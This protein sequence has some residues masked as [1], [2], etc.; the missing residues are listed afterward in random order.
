MKILL[1][2]NTVL[3]TQGTGI[4]VYKETGKFFVDLAQTGN[5]VIVFQ[6]LMKMDSLGFLNDFNIS[7]KGFKIIGVKRGNFKFIAYLKAFFIGYNAVKKADFIYL[8]YPGH[9]CSFLAFS[10][11]LNKKRYG[12]YVR[13][14]KGIMSAISRYLYKRASVVLTISPSFT[15]SIKQL[16]A[17]AYTIRPMMVFDEDDIVRN[18]K[19]INKEQYELLFVGRIERAKGVFEIVEAVRDLVQQGTTN[20]IV[21][22][23]GDGVDASNIKNLIENYQLQRYFSF[24]GIVM[25]KDKLAFYYHQADLF[26]FPSHHEGFPRVLY[27]AMIFGVPVISTYVGSISYLLVDGYNSF[28]VEPNDYNSLAVLINQFCRHYNTTAQI[29]VNGTKTIV[30][31]LADKKDNHA[32]QL[33]K[34]INNQ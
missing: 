29:A 6:Y 22:F 17:N 31:Y 4:Y 15:N 3:Y 30:D 9:I 23:V 13:G 21:N 11:L 2:N 25:D 27:E 33:L 19:Y 20:F 16:G 10:A 26:I 14:E 1:I 34:L 8:F 5:E 32:V 18:R 12:F 7:D 24:A 28:K